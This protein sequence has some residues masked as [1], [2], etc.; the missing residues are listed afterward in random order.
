M[1][2][3]RL[4]NPITDKK[5]D[6]VLNASRRDEGVNRFASR[7]PSSSQKA[8]VASRLDPDLTT[9]DLR[10]QRG[11]TCHSREAGSCFGRSNGL[12]VRWVRGARS[13]SY[14]KPL[15]SGRS[16]SS[17]SILNPA[18]PILCKR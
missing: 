4:D 13:R 15:E 5:R 6:A 12:S 10:P 9:P 18:L 2:D 7:Y 11:Y 16:N 17:H 8:I 3:E 14:T 1:I